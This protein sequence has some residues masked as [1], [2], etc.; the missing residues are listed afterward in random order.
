L[1]AP[2]SGEV[3]QVIA[4]G[5]D[6]AWGEVVDMLGIEK[7]VDPGNFMTLRINDPV[8][9]NAGGSRNVINETKVLSHRA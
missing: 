3:Q 6:R 5:P 8:R 2:P 1:P 4:V 7:V 9:R